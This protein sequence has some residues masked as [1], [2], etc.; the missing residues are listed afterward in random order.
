MLG[1]PHNAVKIDSSSKRRRLDR[2]AKNM[3]TL[4]DK[5]INMITDPTTKIAIEWKCQARDNGQ[6]SRKS[7]WSAFLKKE[8]CLKFDAFL[9]ER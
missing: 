2:Q 3:A 6:L 7:T 4:V 1:S 8:W 9:L 5:D